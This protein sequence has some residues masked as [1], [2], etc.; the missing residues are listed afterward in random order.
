MS[1]RDKSLTELRG[2][3]QS[4]GIEDIFKKDIVQLTQAIEMKQQGMIPDYKPDVPKPQYDARLMNKPPATKSDEHL[5]E[6]Y[7]Y[8]Y[9]NRGIKLTYDQERWYASFDKWTDQGT[10]RMPPKTF[11]RCLDRLLAASHG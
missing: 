10:L 6:E 11:I 9:K 7:A 3:A 2:I 5:L 4:F 1:L 8:P